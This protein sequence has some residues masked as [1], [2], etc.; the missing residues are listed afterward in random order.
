LIP[1]SS[2]LAILDADPYAKAGMHQG[3]VLV[4]NEN[5]GEQQ[6]MAFKALGI[7]WGIWSGRGRRIAE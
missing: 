5:P 4:I 1:G 3:G 7:L 2:S 6:L